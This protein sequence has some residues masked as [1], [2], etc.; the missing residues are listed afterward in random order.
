VTKL[1]LVGGRQRTERP[2]AAGI[3]DWYEYEKAVI[4]ALDTD[5]GEAHTVVE[6]VSPPE[7]RPVDEPT[8]LF[9]SGTLDGDR[10]YVCTQTEILVYRLPDFTLQDYLSLPMFNDLH[11]VCPTADGTV[12]VANTGLD[13][14]IEV[15]FDGTVVREW[16]TLG[17]DTWARFSRDVD[18]RRVKTTKP[19]RSHPNYVF[20]LRNEIWAT[21]FEQRDAIS[22]TSPGLRIDIGHERPHDGV[23]RDGRVLFTTVDGK[24]PVA[25]EAALSITETFDLTRMRPEPTILGWCRGLAFDSDLLWVG[26]SRLRPTK[27]RENVGW[28]LRGF[29]HELGT[30]VAC[31]DLERQLCVAEI[32]VEPFGLNAIFSIFVPGHDRG[33]RA[34]G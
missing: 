8:I 14:V 11:H 12:L 23:V 17:E 3:G 7:T 16:N 1:Y 21:R 33:D 10:L 15:R 31:Y 13:T 26:F 20:H 5:T 4:L 32:D 18:Y 19:H 27:F 22:L 25:D 24:I 34:S 9:K 29:R 28:V 6:Y 30:H 2:L